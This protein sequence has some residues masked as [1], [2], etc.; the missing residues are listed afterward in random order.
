M[1]IGSKENGGACIELTKDEWARLRSGKR[2]SK[3]SGD[4]RGEIIFD[5]K[6]TRKARK[7]SGE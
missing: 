5:V 3:L 6:M 7:A 1:T 4:R 2:V